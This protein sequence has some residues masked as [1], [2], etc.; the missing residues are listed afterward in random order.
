MKNELR[1]SEVTKSLWLDFSNRILLKKKTRLSREI[2]SFK[3]IILRENATGKKV[4][5]IDVVEQSVIGGS[6]FPF[7]SFLISGL[8]QPYTTSKKNNKK[9]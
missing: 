4:D 3:K 5:S 7:I 9:N 8:S 6:I 2:K 1:T